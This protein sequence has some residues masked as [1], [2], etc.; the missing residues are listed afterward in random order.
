MPGTEE[1]P[2]VHSRVP[3]KIKEAGD[4]VLYTSLNVPE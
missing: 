2:E 3:R 1:E 4:D